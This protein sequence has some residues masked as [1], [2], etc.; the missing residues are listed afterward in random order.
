[1]CKKLYFLCRS[2]EDGKKKQHELQIPI[3]IEKK[4]T[5]KATSDLWNNQQK[6]VENIIEIISSFF[7]FCLPQK[8]KIINC[9]FY[10]PDPPVAV[11]ATPEKTQSKGKFNQVI[12]HFLLKHQ[13]NLMVFLLPLLLY[14]GDSLSKRKQQKT[15]C[16]HFHRFLFV[17]PIKQR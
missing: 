14:V 4:H 3:Y 8:L 15:N 13:L 5:K 6:R 1:M 9:H 17:H 12:K 11:T 10:A 7:V 2:S 16:T